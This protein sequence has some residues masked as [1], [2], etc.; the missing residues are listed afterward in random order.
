MTWLLAP[1]QHGNQAAMARRL[2]IMYVIWD[3]KV[4]K[5]YQA[6]RGWPRWVR[7]HR[8]WL[9][10]LEPVCQGFSRWVEDTRPA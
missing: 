8:S 1:D 7:E 4:W 6:G 2:G 10:A 9:V 5:S 3:A